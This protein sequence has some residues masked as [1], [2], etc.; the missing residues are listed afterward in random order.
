MLSSLVCVGKE[1]T[2]PKKTFFDRRFGKEQCQHSAPSFSF[3]T[4]HVAKASPSCSWTP[5]D[6]VPRWPAIAA[7]YR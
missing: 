5:G 6:D 2:V 1:Y 3:P 4:A 7:E